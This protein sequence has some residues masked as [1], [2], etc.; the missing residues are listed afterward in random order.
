MKQF[1]AA[2]A[3]F[4]LSIFMFSTQVAAAN[5]VQINLN[6]AYPKSDSTYD[7]VV[8]DS[9]G[10]KLALYVNDKNP[11]YATV[12]SHAWT[13]FHKVKA[14]DSD[15]LSF[16]KVL[17]SK[18]N[19]YQKP[20]NYVRYFQSNGGSKVN[21]VPVLPAKPV[22]APTIRPVTPAPTVN[23]PTPAPVQQPTCTNGS[24]VNS[25]GNT[26]CSPE[27]APSAPAG[28]TAKCVDGTYSFSQSHSGTCSHHGG[29][30]QWL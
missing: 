1:R 17:K 14:V 19:S 24:Y 21:F 6:N 5:T 12:N 11:V 28:A 20:I 30:A 3:T 23:V 13:T 2:I 18:N 4:I 15:K 26:V 10:I 16:T 29:V 7:V 8:K 22:Q 9:P 25:A 27:T